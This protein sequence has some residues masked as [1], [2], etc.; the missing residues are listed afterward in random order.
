LALDPL[1]EDPP[2]FELRPEAP[3]LPDEPMPVLDEPL[4]EPLKPDELPEE[5]E[6]EEPRP[7][8]EPDPEL[9]RPLESDDPLLRE[10]LDEE[11]LPELEEEPLPLTPSFSLV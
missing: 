11:L 5:L 1:D 3:E 8:L 2:L 6:P 9:P 10:L 7:E 4:E